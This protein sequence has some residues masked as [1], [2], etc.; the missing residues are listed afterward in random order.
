MNATSYRLIAVLFAVGVTLHN[1]EEAMF[2][3]RWERA[4]LRWRFNPD[5]KIYWVVTTLVS[6]VIWILIVGISARPD[7]ARLQLALSGVAL[8]VAINAVF[9]HLVMSLVTRSYMPGAGTGMLLNL[10]LGAWLIHEQLSAH[11]L[12]DIWRQA[13]PYA[14]CLAVGTFGILFGAHAVVAW[15]RHA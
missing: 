7:R 2:L 13:V 6:V 12:V 11:V 15:K 9:P 14:V 5:P 1:L 8:A 10:P 3:V 4:H